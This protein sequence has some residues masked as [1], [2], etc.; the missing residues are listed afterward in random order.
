[1]RLKLS[2]DIVNIKFSP[3]G[4]FFVGKSI[5]IKAELYGDPL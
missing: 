1:M 3:L 5:V 4:P 2:R